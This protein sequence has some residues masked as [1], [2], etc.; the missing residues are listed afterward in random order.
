MINEAINELKRYTEGKQ[1]TE[2]IEISVLALNRIILALEQ[3]DELKN[4]ASEYSAYAE[5][6]LSH[7]KP[8]TIVEADKGE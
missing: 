6:I 7:A 3:D 2:K 1:N 5:A 8:K 4:N